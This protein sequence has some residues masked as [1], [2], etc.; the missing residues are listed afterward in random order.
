MI[1]RLASEYR[2]MVSNLAT[3]LTNVNVSRARAELR[4]LVGE[5]EVRE[6]PETVEL[7]SMQSPEQ[8]LLRGAGVPQK[9]CVVAGVGFEPTTFGL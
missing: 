7:W 8:A 1:P 9:I 3:T 4:K 5:I 2:A 6:S